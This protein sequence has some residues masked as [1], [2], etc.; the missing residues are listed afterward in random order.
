MKWGFCSSR[1]AI[2]PVRSSEPAEKLVLLLAPAETPPVLAGDGSVAPASMQETLWEITIY[3][4]LIEVN[5]GRSVITLWSAQQVCVHR[6]PAPLPRVPRVGATMVG[7]SCQVFD[8]R[9]WR[10]PPLPAP[11]LHLLRNYA[12]KVRAR[13]TFAQLIEQQ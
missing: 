7:C 5:R 2:D 1:L 4:V 6:P 10:R 3:L 11:Q 12:S 8:A 9:G 13:W